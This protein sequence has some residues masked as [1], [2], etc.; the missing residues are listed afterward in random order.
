VSLVIRVADDKVAVQDNG[1]GIAPEAIAGLFEPFATHGKAGGTGLG[2][3]YC[4][5][6]M[7]AF[8]GKI[9]CESVLGEYTQ[10]TMS[11]PPVNVQERE[12]QRL[13]ALA[14]AKQVFAG[15][16]LLVV[17]DDAAL[18]TMTRHKLLA[19]GA[20]IDEAA[21]GYQAKAL[22]SASKYALVLL[23]L[24]MP[25]MDGYALAEGIRAGFALDNQDVCIVAYT[26]EPA[27][28]A[29]VK[30]KKAGIDGF[31]SKP[32]DQ[33]PLLQALQRAFNDPGTRT[34]RQAAALAGRR[35]LVADD[36]RYQRDVLAAFLKHAGAT[37]VQAA[38]GA[39]VLAQLTGSADWDAIVMDLQMPGMS[40]LETTQAI[41][42]AGMSWSKVPIIAATA[43]SDEASIAAAR[44]AGMNDFITKPVE[45]AELLRKL[46][47]LI[48]A[49]AFASLP[50]DWNSAG[51]GPAAEGE[52]SWLLNA[53]RLESYQRIGIL[54]DLV[55][56]FVPE[57]S[58]LV[59]QLELG[60]A[61][62][63]W[64][65][66]LDTL[67]SLLGISGDA[68]ASALYQLVRTAYLRM[69]EGHAWPSGAAWLREVV[70]V[71]GETLQALTDYC[72]ANAVP[73]PA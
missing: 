17:D 5:R 30:T 19:L 59:T 12:A 32:C 66:T 52:N 34:L 47:Q 58:R 55:N 29:R 10:F 39:E 61:Q 73:N 56:D 65:Q 21:D 71:S 15:R 23:D 9:G 44:E 25:G 41:R 37:V 50:A 54:E 31:V 42:E 60:V 11:F 33:V 20:T 28:L 72:A 68:G 24:N 35:I 13:A 70:A 57:I 7:R 64:Q 69:V 36:S 26:S 6:V 3:A 22:L 38:H 63:N 67:H 2:L 48:A 43:H 51:P 8:G 45:S 40:G 46:S 53:D 14:E 4:L 1:P 62:Q 49:A 16:R 27:H 18:R